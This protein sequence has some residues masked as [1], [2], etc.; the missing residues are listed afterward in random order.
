[1]NH[2]AMGQGA[3]GGSLVA[4]VDSVNAAAKSGLTSVPATVAVGL[5]RGIETQLRASRNASLRSIATDL[6]ALR[7][8]LGRS[9]VNGRQVGAILRRVGPKVTRVASTQSGALATTLRELGGELT[10]AGRSLSTPSAAGATSG[11]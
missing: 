10:T 11:R 7:T 8:E 5:V 2:G 6:R 1:M 4:R 9:T 3:A